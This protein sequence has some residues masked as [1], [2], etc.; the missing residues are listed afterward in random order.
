MIEAGPEG[1]WDTQCMPETRSFVTSAG[2]VEVL[3]IPGELPPVLFFPGGHCSARCDCGWSLY[4]DMGHA[5][6]SFSRPGYGRTRVDAVS[7]AEFAPL[8]REVCEQLAITASLLRSG[9][10]SVACKR[11]TWPTMSS[12]ACPDSFCTA[13]PRPVCPLVA[14]LQRLRKG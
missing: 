3:S 8:V 14:V 2:S 5:I 10:P 4:R 13:A 12:W 6:L 1:D 11:C 9:C 7:P